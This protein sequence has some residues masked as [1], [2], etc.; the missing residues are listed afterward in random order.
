MTKL[1]L[2]WNF[3]VVSDTQKYQK[4]CTKIDQVC[5]MKS[6]RKIVMKILEKPDALNIVLD[7]CRLIY[8]VQIVKVSTKTSESD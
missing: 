7:S 8:R 6:K 4:T 3:E 2:Q 5:R 1:Y